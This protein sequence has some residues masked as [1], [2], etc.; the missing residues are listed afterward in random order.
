M[1]IRLRKGTGS[2]GRRRSFITSSRL[3]IIR[4]MP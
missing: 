2:R 3:K 4:S 1:R